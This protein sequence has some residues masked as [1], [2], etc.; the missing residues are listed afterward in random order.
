MVFCICG[1]LSFCVK[2]DCYYLE[3]SNHLKCTFTYLQYAEKQGNMA[4]SAPSDIPS[5][6]DIQTVAEDTFHYC[7]FCRRSIF[8]ATGW[9]TLNLL[10]LEIF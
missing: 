2:R 9:L 4:A 8:D 7:C 1:P 6:W 10:S 5:E 3:K